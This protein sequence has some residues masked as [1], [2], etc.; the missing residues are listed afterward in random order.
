VSRSRASAEQR[1]AVECPR[2]PR[3]R[4]RPR[5]PVGSRPSSTPQPCPRDVQA[6]DTARPCASA[7]RQMVER[8]RPRRVPMARPS[9]RTI[10]PASAAAAHAP[11]RPTISTR[12]STTPP[13]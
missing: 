6:H 2:P 8:S 7:Q 13:R 12:P 9:R 1:H 3:D 11:R 10:R 4:Q 5:L